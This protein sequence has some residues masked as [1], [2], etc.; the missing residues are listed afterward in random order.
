MEQPLSFLSPPD[1]TRPAFRL[2][3]ALGIVGV[4]I[5]GVGLSQFVHYEPPGQHTGIRAAIRG[6]YDY[7]LKRRQV[8]GAE[9]DHFHTNEPFAAEVDWAELPAD[10]LVGARWFS[11]GFSIDAGGVG[12]AR[13]RDL[14][15]SGPVPVNT[16]GARFP[17]GHY[18][19]VVERYSHGRAVEVLGRTSVLVAG[20][21]A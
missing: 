3:I 19:F 13:A 2:L 11:G 8:T 21:G 7:D 14:V 9:K 17:S 20:A 1:E 16:G 12:P 18:T 5:L 10:L 15:D 6:V 4:V